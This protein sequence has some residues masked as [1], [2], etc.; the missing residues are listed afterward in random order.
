MGEDA[1]LDTYDLFQLTRRRIK[2]GNRTHTCRLLQQGHCASNRITTQGIAGTVVLNAPELVTRSLVASARFGSICIA[3]RKLV[4][5]TLV[6]S[7]PNH[8]CLSGRHVARPMPQDRQSGRSLLLPGSYQL[9]WRLV[10][11]R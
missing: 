6:S 2:R 8:S 5:I 1:I 11:R 4:A 7:D 10:R 9:K 3:S